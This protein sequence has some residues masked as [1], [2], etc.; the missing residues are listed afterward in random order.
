MA[1]LRSP[2]GCAWDRRQTHASLRPYLIEET[3][4]A[5]DAIDRGNL[6]DLAEELGDVLL[7]CVFHAQLGAEAGRFDIVDVIDAIVSK[8]IRRHPHVFTA[9]GAPLSD[10]ARRRAGVDSPDA[11]RE[12][13]QRLKARERETRDEPPHVLAGLPR[14]LPALLRAHKIG[15]RAAEVGFDWPTA[16]GVLDKIEEEVREL[17]AAAA[18]GPAR[19]ADEF[20]DLLFSIA[21]L[22][23]K[24][25]IEPEAALAHA[26]DTF[27]RRFTAL[28][29]D[30][31]ARGQ[32]V[33][34]ASSA[35]LDLAWRRVKQAETPAAP[36]TR[37]RA[38]SAR[39]SRGR[40]SRR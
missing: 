39:E 17:R 33:H 29:D 13:W 11:V 6:D 26:N 16:A 19:Q 28:E 2:Q 1:V 7:Q 12:Q 3:Y 35:D 15:S 4:E 40:R 24:L 30:L 37:V 9:A 25:G 10:A 22:A 32:H 31:A 38:R 14:A 36:A 23:R 21:N 18:E 8:L 20:G 5:V 34:A 27:T